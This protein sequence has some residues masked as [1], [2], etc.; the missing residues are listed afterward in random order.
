MVL[1]ASVEAGEVKRSCRTP[2]FS[3]GRSSGGAAFECETGRRRG[4]AGMAEDRGPGRLVFLIFLQ[5]FV[6]LIG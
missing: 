1:E 6:G 5:S 3:K 2:F 4:F